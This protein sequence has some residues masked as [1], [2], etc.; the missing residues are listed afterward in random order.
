MAR[1]RIFSA[2]AAPAAQVNLFVDGQSLKNDIIA[3]GVAGQDASRGNPFPRNAV[4]EFRIITNNYKAEY[5][6]A[7][8]A[9]ITAVTKS[10]GNTWEGSTFLDY[11]NKDLVSLDTFTASPP[12]DSTPTFVKPDYTRY[13]FGGSAG[14]PLIKDKL[15]F[16]G[17][18]EGNFQHRLGTV[19]LSGD[20]AN[21]PP[22]IGSFDISSHQAPFKENLGF[23]KLT[24]NMSDK[25]L[26]EF[27]GNLRKEHDT[28]DFGGQF[29]G[30][31]K[32]FSAADNQI[33][34][35]Y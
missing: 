2:G 4:Q 14:G 27:T 35:V 28:R 34:N 3:S 33:S 25:Q 12:C 15:F 22:A 32:T 23:A 1:A 19:Q 21:Y 17:T 8:S 30:P 16:F 18:Y 5:Q 20:P 11:Q 9:I 26:L 29:A 6:K 31:D 7:S 24:Y 10:G 13:L